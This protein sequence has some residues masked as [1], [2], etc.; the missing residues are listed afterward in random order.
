MKF[1]IE[2]GIWAGCFTILVC[3]V[4]V[5]SIVYGWVDDWEG[6]IEGAILPFVVAST[7][8]TLFFMPLAYLWGRYF[9]LPYEEKY[10]S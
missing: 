5:S 6:N 7:V 2:V 10:D 3:A 8:F 1:L 9:I 4:T